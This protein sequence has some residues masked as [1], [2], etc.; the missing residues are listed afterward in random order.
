MVLLRDLPQVSVREYKKESIGD[1]I[2][3]GLICRVLF[4]L[5]SVMTW[6]VNGLR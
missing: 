4:V 2:K 5:S 6:L 1:S 3:K